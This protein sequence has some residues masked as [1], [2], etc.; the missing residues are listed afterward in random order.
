MAVLL[1]AGC[2]AQQKE[3]QI[4]N[5]IRELN[6]DLPDEGIEYNALKQKEGK[7]VHTTDDAVTRDKEGKLHFDLT[8]TTQIQLQSRAD[9]KGVIIN[10][11]AQIKDIVESLKNFM[12]YSPVENYEP[13]YDYTITFYQ[14]DQGE[15]AQ[16]KAFDNFIISYE[17]NLYYDIAE[18]FY[19][20]K[21]R[22][23][24]IEAV[25]ETFSI[26]GTVF[27]LNGEIFDLKR[28]ERWD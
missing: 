19:I 7:T 28:L 12:P 23:P 9:H 14:E 17:G 6:A 25:K 20:W 10:N 18:K 8:G 13:E 27:H 4:N 22:E 5:I 26:D 15:L 24:Y 21:V 1:L 16:I 11:P 3:Q 2:G